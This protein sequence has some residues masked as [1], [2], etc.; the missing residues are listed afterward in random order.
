MWQQLYTIIAPTK[1]GNDNGEPVRFFQHLFSLISTKTADG[2]INPKLVLAWLLNALGAP[3][4]FV[5]ALVPIRESGA[6]L[7][8]ILLAQ[9][10]QSSPVRKYY[11]AAGSFLQGFAAIGIAISAFLLEGAAAGWAIIGCLAVLSFARAACSTS[12]KDILSRTLQK[13]T[14]GT[15]SG[16]A[17]T[18][19]ATLVFAF[20]VL[21]SFGIIPLE[22]QSLA[23]AIMVAG[24]LWILGAFIFLG[25]NEEPDDN[26]E[27]D[28][29][30]LSK[31][32]KPLRTDGEFRQY[33]LVRG[34]FISTA[35][36]PPFLVMLSSNASDGSIG[37]LG[38]L[39]IASSVA[40]IVSSYIWGRLSDQSSRYTLVIAGFVAS[41]ALGVAAA[42]GFIT[43]GAGNIIVTAALVFAAQIGYEGARAGRKTHLTDLDRP[44][45]TAIYTALSNTMIGLL[46]LAGG[47]F[48]VLADFAGPSTV[49]AIFAI[50]SLLGAIAALSLS[51]VQEQSE[52]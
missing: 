21:L 50:L 29:K 12:Y 37:N 11:W 19:A 40:A 46:L 33:I 14:R 36:A 42:L 47:G 35:L 34:L 20:A 45:E 15:V 1:D 27:S 16:T 30:N 4:F 13:G 38:L 48:G 18:I 23:I 31:I 5:G 49:L 32:L 10:I 3:G 44:G 41:G 43:G 8:Q 25:L 39:L 7:P 6:L 24:A 52:D 28:I 26:A 51:E 2:I 9:K 17:G 22:T